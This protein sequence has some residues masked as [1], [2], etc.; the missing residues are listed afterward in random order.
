VKISQTIAALAFALAPLGVSGAYAA[1]N[2]TYSINQIIGPGSEIGTITT[3]GTIG[4][5]S[6]LNIVG[7]NLTLNDGSNVV[8]LI[9]PNAIISVNSNACCSG[10]TPDGVDLTASASSLMF[11]YSGSDSGDFVIA[12][13]LGSVCYTAV[14][15]CWGPTGVGL[16]SVNGDGLSVYIAQSGNQII[17]NAVPEPAT[18]ALM[19]LGFGGIGFAMRRSRK[20]NGAALRTA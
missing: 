9:W 13:S 20:R 16:Y 17:G 15:N 10:G 18:W 1:S 5:L 3:D 11:N 6:A 2:I 12:S 19:L 8:N 14:S 7:F 4:T